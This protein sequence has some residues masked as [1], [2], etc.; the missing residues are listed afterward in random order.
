MYIIIIILRSRRTYSNF[1]KT[2]LF[3]TNHQSMYVYRWECVSRF[4]FS[5]LYIFVAVG[6]SRF[7]FFD[8]IKTNHKT[9]MVTYSR[10][11]TDNKERRHHSSGLMRSYNDVIENKKIYASQKYIVSTVV[12]VC[13]V[14]LQRRLRCMQPSNPNP[15]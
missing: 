12:A 4:F 2:D 15:W 8:R 9:V 14:L 13:S 3:A 10:R 6:P 11:Q 1:C 7:L 5:A